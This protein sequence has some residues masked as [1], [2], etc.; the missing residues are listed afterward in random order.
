MSSD[1]AITLAEAGALPPS[2][3]GEEP[4]EVDVY[5]EAPEIDTT[6]AEGQPSRLDA[7]CGSNAHSRFSFIV[8]A[9][10]LSLVA[11]AVVGVVRVLLF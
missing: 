9:C 5:S 2:E 10:A 6:R 1:N 11:G 7:C 3:E 8:N 4:R